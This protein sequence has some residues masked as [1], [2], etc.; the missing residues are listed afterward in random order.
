MRKRRGFAVILL[1]A[2]FC[3]CSL[4]AQEVR[5]ALP[6]E[7]PPTARAV[8]FDKPTPSPTAA[9]RPSA[10]PAATSTPAG[11]PPETTPAPVAPET[12]TPDVRQLNYAN[13]FF[14]RKL[15]DLAIPEY[16][17]FLGQFPGAPGRAGAYF[18]LGECYRALGRTPAARS[19][20][21]SVIDEY[22][23]SEF[24]GPAAYGVAEIEFKE[25]DF[26][27]AL[28]LFHRAAEKTKEAGLALSARYFEARCLESLGRKD[29]AREIYVQVA[30]VKDPNPFRDDARTAAGTLFLARGRKLEAFKQFEALAGETS[31]PGLKAE[32]AIRAGLLA[33]ELQG[34]EKSS[35][36]QGMIDRAISL[37]QKGKAG[38]ETPKWRSLAAVG[39]L[40]LYYQSGRSQQVIA[41]FKKSQA[42]LP[43]EIKPELMLLV[44]NSHRQLN[45]TEAA[46]ELYRQISAKYPDREEAKD[47][48]YQRLI[49]LYSSGSKDLEKEIDAFL[50]TNP[51]GERGDQARLLKAEALYQQGQL[52]EAIP[53]YRQVRESQLAPK[54]RAEAALKLA[55]AHAQARNSE[56][57]NEAL[58][59][60]LE[61]FPDHAQTPAVLTQRAMAR[62]ELKNYDEALADLNLLLQKYP[63]ASQ[64]E[65]AL[66]QKA[67]LLGQQEKNREMAGTFQQ[68]LKEFPKTSVAAQANYFIG[69]TSLE[70]KNYK[71]AI[72]P[73]NAARTIDRAQYYDLA[74]VRIISSHFYLRDR[75]A[76]VSEI[77]QYLASDPGAP[78]PAEILEWLGLDFYNEKKFALVDKYLTALSRLENTSGVKPDFW[79]YLGDARNRLNNFAGAE[80]AFQQYL[81]TATDPAGRAKVLLA[82]G[83]A[84]LKASKPEEAQRVAE[85]IMS[86]QPEGRVNAEARLLLGDVQM[87]REEFE[88]AGKAF[89]S[90]AL[91]HDDPE[92]TP[93]ALARAAAA[94]TRAGQTEEAERITK[95]LRERYPEFAG[96]S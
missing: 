30:G 77:D 55:S 47:A 90:V 88:A 41:E 18:F 84:K 75:N 71:Q 48:Q 60:F 6:V 28:P 9:P 26:K 59:F 76:L 81:T 17:K 94:Y 32:A 45:Q 83:E 80:E 36:D 66:Q 43:E 19:S 25:K 46:E 3:G 73:L 40:R 91:L 15:F 58:T 65:G 7:E 20:F 86:L 50:A 54:L 22:P 69:K 12:E 70:E 64:R 35:T 89:M 8:P 61:T 56:G 4:F 67:L 85:E 82:L 96:G 10:T 29:D 68:L 63:K 95:Q 39:L 87:Q 13:A 79:F 72:R 2:G 53:L 74:T 23:E 62:Q 38:A 42:D 1:I 5:R 33:A 24:A 27:N 31:K 51:E 78:V 52:A 49:N 34:T 21:Q 92:I 37:L 14:A 44:A 11:A 16:E 57:V 93:R